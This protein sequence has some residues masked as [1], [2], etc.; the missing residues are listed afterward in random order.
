MRYVLNF[1]II[2]WVILDRVVI[3]V[4]LG[5]LYGKNLCGM[6][7]DIRDIEFGRDRIEECVLEYGDYNY[8]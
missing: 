5:F 4:R 8:N 3:L 7:K 2:F 6:D 1:Y